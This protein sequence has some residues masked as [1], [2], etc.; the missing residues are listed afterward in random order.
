VQGGK[1]AA[2][3][4]QQQT[5]SISS[6][7]EPCVQAA[8]LRHPSINKNPQLICALQLT[9]KDLQAALAELAAGEL[10][11][12]LY[13]RKPHHA[14][15]FAQWLQKHAGLLQQLEV[16]FCEC[17][18][19]STAAAL[20]AFEAGLQQAAASGK[21]QLQSFSITGNTAG[22]QVSLQHLPAAHLTHLDAAVDLASA[23][24]LQAVAALTGLKKLELQACQ[25]LWQMM[26]YHSWQENYSSSQSCI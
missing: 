18:T 13:H 7:Q 12:Q 10:C 19:G 15:S 22:S 25:Q 9:S 8:L 11:L 5:R 2:A 1:Q 23:A 20:T 21:L 17:C 6:M 3:L 26:P 16:A 24:S 4:L 14:E